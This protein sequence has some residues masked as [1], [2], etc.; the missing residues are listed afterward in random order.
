MS[1]LEP[2]PFCRGKPS[3]N[4]MKT[5]YCQLHGEPHQDYR[6]YCKLCGIEIVGHDK[7]TAFR[8]W[9]TRPE[10]RQDWDEEAIEK[11]V[12]KVWCGLMGSMTTNS[13]RFKEIAK[14]LI[15]HFS[16][17]AKVVWPEKMKNAI[18]YVLRDKIMIIQEH[19]HS[20]YGNPQE[21]IDL[22]F[23]ACLTEFKRLNPDVGEGK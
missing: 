8:K 1:E 5:I 15:H 21:L 16:P 20:Y 4:I 14:S 10:L 13:E 6:V 19:H 23:N 18:E 22:L 12:E 3:H 7:E 9:N 2:C 17:P 11:I